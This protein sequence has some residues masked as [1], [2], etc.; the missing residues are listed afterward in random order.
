VRLSEARAFPL[1]LRLTRPLVTAAGEFAV[2]ESVILELRDAEGARGLGEAAPWPGF[3]DETPAGSRAALERALPLLRGASL[4]P[5]GWPLDLVTLLADAPLARAAVEAALCDLAA[6]RAA[7]PLAAYLH[8]AAGPVGGDVVPGEVAVNALL[9]EREPEALRAEAARVREAGFLAAKLK[10]GGGPLVGDIARVRA[11]RDGL[12]P[13]VA[14]RLDANG[15]WGEAQAREALAALAPFRPDYVE[16]PVAAGE[17]ETLA[18]LRAEGMARLAADEAL[19]LPGGLQRV[20]DRAAA[21]V[22][23]LKPSLLGG[24]LAALAAARRARAAGCAVVFTHVFESA[25]GRYHALHCAAAWADPEAVHGLAG[26][27]P[28][29]DD[30]GA[31]PAVGSGRLV[32][33]Q[34]PG[35]GLEVDASRWA[36]GG[37]A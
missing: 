7:Q 14:L 27:S 9:V 22:V 21:D 15:S 18:R 4:E 26:G 30:I 10:V 5:A 13:H 23:V 33:P 37:E 35:L 32:L 20:I 24:P 19:S 29:R 12:G 28:F 1:R 36:E 6:R 11:A 34:A 25:I 31:L 17:V 2:R 8:A 3:G 16:Q